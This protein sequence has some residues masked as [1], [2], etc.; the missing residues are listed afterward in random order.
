MQAE[1]DKAIQE[2]IVL[3]AA[4]YLDKQHAIKYLQGNHSTLETLRKQGLR[5]HMVGRRSYYRKAD[6]NRLIEKM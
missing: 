5:R 2:A 1:I 4:D 3:Y 6:I